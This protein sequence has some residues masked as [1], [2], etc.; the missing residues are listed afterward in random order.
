MIIAMIMVIIVRLGHPKGQ[1]GQQYGRRCRI[2]ENRI[3]EETRN[4]SK[5]QAM[6]KRRGKKRRGYGMENRKNK[7]GAVLTALGLMVGTAAGCSSR[8][9]EYQTAE[10]NGEEPFTI[11]VMLQDYSGSPMS[12][13]YADEVLE[14]LESYMNCQIDFSWVATKDYEDKVGMMLAQGEGMPMVMQVDMNADVLSAARAG[15]FWDLT[16]FLPDEENLPN[17]SQA[18]ETIS[19]SF[20]VD[21]QLIGIY[22]SRPI[23]RYGWSYRQDWADALGIPEPRTVEDFYQMLYQF[24]YDD[25]DGNGKD[26]TYGLCLCKHTVPFDTMQTWFGVGNGW[27]EQNGEL[28]PVHQT[29][30]YMEALNWFRNIYEEGLVYPD[31]AVRDSDTWLDGVRKGECGVLV[32]IIGNGK[33]IWDY[34]IKNQVPAV[35]GEGYASMKLMVG[36]AKDEDSEIR[37]LATSGNGGCFVITKA[38]DTKEKVMQCLQFL[39]KL[40]DN[41]MHILMDFGLEGINWEYQDGYLVDLD[42]DQPELSSAYSG[43]NQLGNVL[44]SEDYYE[45]PIRYTQQKAAE[46]EKQKEAEAYVVKNPAADYLINSETY[47]TKGTVL[48]SILTEARTQYIVGEIDEIGLEQAWKQWETQGG[49]ALMEEI[50]EQY[51]QEIGR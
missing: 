1:D 44:Y 34:F 13:E 6:G 26:D 36:L 15:T 19:R 37:D 40:N 46:L 17:L 18:D 29:S 35:T 9:D 45:V 10:Q 20:L 4:P 28:I 50:N 33:G 16:E 21:G 32:D 41:E 42:L 47:A 12:G 22:R 5:F 38:A 23:G 39:D 43:L 48:D 27:V 8:I 24:T 7:V 49:L 3:F 14:K 31:F 51:R 25:P 11:T 30:E 2:G